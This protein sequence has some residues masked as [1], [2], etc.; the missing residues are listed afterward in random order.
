MSMRIAFLAN[1]DNIADGIDRVLTELSKLRAAVKERDRKEIEALLEAARRK[2]ASL[3][4][5]KIR[6]KE[7]LS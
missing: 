1:A 6:K 4:K 3:I 5:Y 7:L 2:R